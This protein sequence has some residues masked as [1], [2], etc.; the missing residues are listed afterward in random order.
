MHD[1]IAFNSL[2]E[3][4]VDEVLTAHVTKDILPSLKTIIR[5]KVLLKYY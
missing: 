4:L 2:V 5:P 1:P 3:A